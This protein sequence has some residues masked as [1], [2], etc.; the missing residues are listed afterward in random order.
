MP[1]WDHLHPVRRLEHRALSKGVDPLSLWKALLWSLSRL[2][3]SKAAARC[4]P[5]TSFYQK[6]KKA[7]PELHLALG[8]VGKKEALHSLPC[9]QLLWMDV[10]TSNNNN[11]WGYLNIRHVHINGEY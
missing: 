5:V 6:E 3:L 2:G 10:N 8:P 11:Y 9:L 1:I 4:D 7:P